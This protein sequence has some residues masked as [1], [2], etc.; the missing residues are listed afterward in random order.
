MLKPMHLASF[1]LSF[2]NKHSIVLP[3]QSELDLVTRSFTNLWQLQMQGK[4]EIRVIC[5]S[6]MLIVCYR[7]IFGVKTKDVIVL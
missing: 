7:E 3:L 2:K 1:Q 6:L 5:I 4:N